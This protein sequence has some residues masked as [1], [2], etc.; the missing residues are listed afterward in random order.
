MT[1]SKENRGID[2]TNN[3]T[4]PRKYDWLIFKIKSTC[5]CFGNLVNKWAIEQ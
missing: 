5:Y 4:T 1:K 2:M 3:I